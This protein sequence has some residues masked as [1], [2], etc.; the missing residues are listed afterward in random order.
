[1]Y[2]LLQ[3]SVLLIMSSVICSG[4]FCDIGL[5][6]KYCLKDLSG[7]H[8]CRKDPKT[9]HMTDTVHKCKGNTRFVKLH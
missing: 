2:S 7:Y 3:L 6:G 5:P 8:D 9:G 4:E 1:M